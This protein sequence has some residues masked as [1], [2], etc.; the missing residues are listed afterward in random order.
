MPEWIDIPGT[1]KLQPGSMYT[2]NVS[3]TGILV[4]RT[5]DGKYRAYLNKCGHRGL[6]LE[7]GKIVNNSII[8]PH[9]SAGFDADS[10]AVTT[11]PHIKFVPQMF[12]K[13]APLSAM[14]IEAE[15][16]KLRVLL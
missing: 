8:C 6:S 5:G 9:H 14:K 15:G 7:G 2:V 1:D 4:V 10:G 16:G 13:C 3:G 11:P 12:V